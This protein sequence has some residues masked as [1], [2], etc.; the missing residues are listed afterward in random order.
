MKDS[1]CVRPK[2]LTMTSKSTVKQCF[3]YITLP[4]QT[5]AVTAA[6]YELANPET[7]PVGRFVYGKSYLARPDAV[8]IDPVELR[9]GAKIEPTTKLNGIYGA[10]RDASPDYWG[11]LIIERAN[12]VAKLD[13]MEY[14]LQSSDARSGALSF[15]HNNAPPAPDRHF[16]TILDLEELQET[17]L[18]LLEDKKKTDAAKAEQA[19]RLLLVGTAMGGAR[20]KA[21]VQDDE[22]LWIAKF[23]RPEDR[24]DSAKVEHTMLQLAK[25]CGV[26]VA[27]S[28]V[29]T[30]GNRNVLLVKRFDREKVKDGY[31]RARMVSA[32]TLLR[33]ED[34][35]EARG[36]G[37]WSYLALV[38]ALRRVSSEPRRDAKELFCRMCF[39]SAASNIDDHARN[40]AVI[41]MDK[42]WRLSPAYDLTP[43]PSVGMERYLQMIAGNQGT[44]ASAENLLSQAARFLVEPD[45]AQAIVAEVS[46]CVRTQWYRIARK[47][48]VTEADCETIRSAFENEGFSF[49]TQPVTKKSDPRKAPA[50]QTP[51]KTGTTTADSKKSSTKGRS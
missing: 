14:L 41:A 34:S 23:N 25:A 46:K 11:R 17:A 12:R 20:P 37:E 8:E 38:E 16:N 5:Q 40:H 44:R 29:T 42:S 13:E 45:E 43:S 6:K 1:A 39:N 9:L 30:I 28:R 2:G 3:V 10:I 31:L 27:H 51:G 32:L 36:R 22:G 21:V 15:G 33:S 48:H 47:E 50:K 35:M 7:N 24:W 18:A 4:G 49:Q 26:A 19:R